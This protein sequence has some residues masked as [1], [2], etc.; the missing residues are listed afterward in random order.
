MS[1]YRHAL[2]QRAPIPFITDGGIETTLVYRDGFDLPDFA[3]FHLLG[4]ATGVAALQRYFRRYASIAV[5]HR[6]GLI[7]ES[8][9]WRA[10]SDWGRRLGYTS[11]MLVEANRRAIS[12]LEV[13][14][15][16]VATPE[17]PVVISGCIGPRGDGYIPSLAM[18]AH[19]A[20]CYHHT[21]IATFAST[22]ADQV[23]AMTMNYT[24]EAIGIVRAARSL[25]MPVAISFT[26]ETD[27]RLPTGQL[28]AD[29][30]REVDDATDGAPAYYM[31][32][33]A[34]PSHFAHVLGDGDPV[35][36]RLRGIRANASRK[37]HAELNEATVLDSGDP[38]MFGVEHAELRALHPQLTILGG[39]CGTDHRHVEAIADQSYHPW[40]RQPALSR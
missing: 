19:Q 11:A 21:Q 23:T 36:A 34:H 2:P 30:I 7:L 35:W 31:I 1:R 4:T 38:E 24:A 17:T 12:M 25:A 40:S 9:T 32:N 22:V 13:I 3:A 18:D 14:R 16:D 27:G 37:S 10:S 26:V 29:A 15:A 39:C 33:C 20:E 28:L 6:V 5:R 8:A